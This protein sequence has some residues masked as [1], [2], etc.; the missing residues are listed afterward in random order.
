MSQDNKFA[1][2]T[3]PVSENEDFIKNLE[4]LKLSA[5]ASDGGILVISNWQ[6]G[7]SCEKSKSDAGTV[8]SC[9]D[10]DRIT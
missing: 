10:E 5:T 3:V 4:S 9:S 6:T 7:T 1:T 8:Y 2:I